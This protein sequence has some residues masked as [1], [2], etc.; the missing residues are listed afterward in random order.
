MIIAGEPGLQGLHRSRII[1][2]RHWR[3][4]L[5]EQSLQNIFLHISMKN[6]ESYALKL[7][8][9]PDPD[10]RPNPGPYIISDQP[11]CEFCS[12]STMKLDLNDRGLWGQE[13]TT[14]IPKR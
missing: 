12:L 3:L 2:T 7:K 6:A 4:L 14:T 8:L 13:N 9:D 10:L 11:W 1:G 5:H